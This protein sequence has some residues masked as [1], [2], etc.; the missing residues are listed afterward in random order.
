MPIP[1]S[2]ARS[3]LTVIHQV[4]ANNDA[5]HALQLGSGRG[6]VRLAARP[7]H[8]H[9]PATGTRHCH[10]T[11]WPHRPLHACSFV[12]VGNISLMRV[13]MEMRKMRLTE[14][15]PGECATG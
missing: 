10:A 13:M 6:G 15:L 8:E 3:E 9:C 4:E 14:D 1:P 2:P 11:P 12:Y 7:C 5:H